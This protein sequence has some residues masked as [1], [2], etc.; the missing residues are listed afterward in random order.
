MTD[1]PAITIDQ[2]AARAAT[3]HADTTR[4]EAH[5]ARTGRIGPE[6]ADRDEARLCLRAVLSN[7]TPGSERARKIKSIVDSDHHTDRYLRWCRGVSSTVAALSLEAY[8]SLSLETWQ[9]QRAVDDFVAGWDHI[10]W[11]KDFARRY[12]ASIR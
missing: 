7:V 5:K 10:A 2:D 9:T 4:L 8:E 3:I 6:P 11:G 12:E 1:Q